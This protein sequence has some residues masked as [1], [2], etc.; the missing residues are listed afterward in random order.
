MNR[1]YIGPSYQREAFRYLMEDAD[2]VTSENNIR[3]LGISDF[4]NSPHLVNKRAY[5]NNIWVLGISDFPN[6]PHLVNKRAYDIQLESGEVQSQY[7][8][9][10]GFKP[11]ALPIG[12]YTMVVEFLPPEMDNNVSVTPEGTTISISKHATHIFTKYTKSL[13][14]FHRWNSTPPQFTWTCTGDLA[15]K[16]SEVENDP[17][18]YDPAFSIEEGQMVLQTDLSLNGNRLIRPSYINNGYLDS[19]KSNPR[20]VLNGVDIISFP[21]GVIFKRIDVIACVLAPALPLPLPRIRKFP[22]CS[23]RLHTV[24]SLGDWRIG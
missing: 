18:V 2:E 10:I 24:P 12:Y 16:D 7:R 14:N 19:G 4:P 9:R 5:E 3:V 1:S 23:F 22:L 8:S 15:T 11:H 13:I 17:K 6:S 21:A 20:F